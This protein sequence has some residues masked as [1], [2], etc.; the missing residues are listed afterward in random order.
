MV[1]R[2]HFIWTLSNALHVEVPFPPGTFADYL[3]GTV[4]A[5]WEEE[6]EWL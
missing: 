3:P 5:V 1:N 6:I 4:S 2:V